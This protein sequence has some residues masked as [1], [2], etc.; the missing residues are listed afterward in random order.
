M[1]PQPF[2]FFSQGLPWGQQSAWGAVREVSC[3][4]A[5]AIPPVIGSIATENATKFTKM[6]RPIFMVQL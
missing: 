3:D 2:V 4:V 5:R 1:E 6:V